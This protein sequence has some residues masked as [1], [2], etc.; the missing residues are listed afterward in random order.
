VRNA[1]ASL[2]VIGTLLVGCKS[3][4]RADS[5]GVMA[6]VKILEHEAMASMSWA[7]STEGFRHSAAVVLLLLIVAGVWSARR[8]PKSEEPQS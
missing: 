1:V 2:V 3:S 5:P 4:P 7:M 6:D 8:S